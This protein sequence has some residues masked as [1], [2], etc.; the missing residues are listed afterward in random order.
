M[1]A[2]RPRGLRRLRSAAA[3]MV[4]ARD[5][6]AERASLREASGGGG[7]ARAS[8]STGPASPRVAWRSGAASA[9]ASSAHPAK[10]MAFATPWYVA[11]AE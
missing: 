1:L 8:Y 11:I 7:G 2:R 9:Y 4:G 10:P 6:K 5:V 3:A